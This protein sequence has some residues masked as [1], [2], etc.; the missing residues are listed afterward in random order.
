MA[1]PYP[2]RSIT[3]SE[4]NAFHLV[5]QHAFNHGPLAPER[6]E[7]ARRLREYDRTLAAFD[8]SR[9]VGTTYSYSFQLSV[10]G[11]VIPAAGVSLVSVLP[12]HRRRGVLR[13]LMRRQ[14]SDITQRGEPIAALW[15]SESVLYGRYGYGAATWQT[16]FTVRRHVLEP[17]PLVPDDLLS[18]DALPRCLLCPLGF[19]LR[20]RPALASG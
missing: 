10:P 1:D 17:V 7:R 20:R 16:T 19:S 18:A 11:A 4:F 5:K 2:I 9:I 14:L 8:D 12:T 3:E 15:A 13:S 6:R